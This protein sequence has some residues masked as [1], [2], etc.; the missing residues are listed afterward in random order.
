MTFLSPTVK[1]AFARAS[2]V[3]CGGFFRQYNPVKFAINL[4]STNE[5]DAKMFLGWFKCIELVAEYFDL[6]PVILIISF[7]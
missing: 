6:F 5:V 1:H 7:L 3:Q 2:Q 4:S